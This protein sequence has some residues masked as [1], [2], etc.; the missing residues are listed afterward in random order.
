MQILSFFEVA[1]ARFGA[2]TVIYHK[3]QG[4]TI[5]LDTGR[6]GEYHQDIII[7]LE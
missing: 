6:A 1:A 3:S 5:P 4:D 2:V 7:L